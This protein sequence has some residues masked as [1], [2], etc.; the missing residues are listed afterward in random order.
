MT[1]TSTARRRASPSG[2]KC[3][4]SPRISF[5]SS[6]SRRRAGAASAPVTSAAGA[7]AVISHEMWQS[8]FA[9][10]RGHPRA[11]DPPQRRRA[12]H[13]RR[14]A[15]RLRLS[16]AG[17]GC[18]A[19]ARLSPRDASDHTDHYLAVI[20]RLARWLERGCRAPRSA[21]RRAR[22][23][24][25]RAGSLSG[26]R[27]LEHR[28]RVAARE[29]VRP[30]A[31]AARAA[32]GGRRR[33]AA[34][35]V[36]QRRDHVAAARPRPAPR[37]LDPPRHR[38]HAP[39]RDSATGGRGGGA[40]RARRR[41]RTAARAASGSALSKAFAPAGIPRLQEAAINLPTALFTGGVLVVVT[42]LVGLAPAARRD[43]HERLR[44][45]GPDRPLVGRPRDDAP[46]RRAD[47]DGDRARRLAARLRRPDAAQPARAGRA[48][49]W[50]SRPSTASPSRPT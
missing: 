25:R 23:A 18:V 13:R 20:G 7:I 22:A 32:H 41:R 10:R 4:A 1:L 2:S 40:L 39:R 37:D 5:R 43:P 3:R 21:A 34:H 8:R 45:N 9:R 33:G 36:R 46:A 19:A 35:R 16:G 27:A 44:G 38:R 48:S 14:H 15:R 29:P 42:L 26:R 17:H 28:R 49:T 50:A 31:A 47:G 6:A 30:H 12:R 11:H 24:A